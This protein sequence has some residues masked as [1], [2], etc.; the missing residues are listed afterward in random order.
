MTAHAPASVKIVVAG[1]SQVANRVS[2]EA[3]CELAEWQPPC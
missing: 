3:E 2:D 1:T